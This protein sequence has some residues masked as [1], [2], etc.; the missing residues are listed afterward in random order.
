MR[1][2][3]VIALLAGSALA[4]QDAGLVWWGLLPG[5]SA[6]GAVHNAAQPMAAGN[7]RGPIQSIDG[8]A[9]S[10]MTVTPAWIGLGTNINPLAHATEF[11]LAGWIRA[12][13]IGSSWNLCGNTPS[14]SA[15]S[16]MVQFTA[17]SATRLACYIYTTASAY[18][19][20]DISGLPAMT[21]TQSWVHLAVTWAG[22]TNLALYR[23]GIQYRTSYSSVGSPSNTMGA[24]LTHEWRL[25]AFANGVNGMVNTNAMTNWRMYSRAISSNEL[26]AL[27]VRGAVEGRP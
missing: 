3:A 23:N 5:W 13:S 27:Y 18:R 21:S 11:T 1:L 9:V 14:T 17:Y 25:G 10:N 20:M 6:S 12:T 4:G 16:N 7:T 15:G 22:G 24:N 26:F 8:G 2:A 19:A